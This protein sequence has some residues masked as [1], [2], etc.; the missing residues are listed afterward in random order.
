MKF[1]IN[2]YLPIAI[3]YFF[4]NPLGLPWGLLYTSLLAPFFYI[5]ILLK[6][7]EEPVFPFIAFFLPFLI[8]HIAVVGVNVQQY[9]VTMANLLAVYIFG[10]AFYTWLKTDSRK[11]KVLRSVL[12]INTAL[13]LLAVILYFTPLKNLVW[14][15]Q[16]LTNDVTDFLRLKMFTYEASYYAFLFVPVFLFFFLQYIL[17]KNTIRPFGLLVMLFLPFVLSFSA[18]VIA[19]LLASGF[20]CFFIH[21]RTL[22]NK[23]R[24]V[25]GFINITT[26]G[27]VIFIIVYIFFRGNPIFI[28]LEN[29]IT[30]NDTSASGRTGDAFVLAG[31]L[32]QQG[33]AWWG[34]GAGQLNLEGADLIRGYYL[35]Y[36]N[37]P[38]AIPNAA[39]ETLALFGWLG[40]ILRVAA[41]L[42]FFVITKSW[43]NYFRF[44][45]FVFVFIYQFT[46]SYI[47]NAAEYVIWILAFTNAFPEFDVPGRKI[48]KPAYQLS[49]Q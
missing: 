43:K 2:K 30:G 11:E 42:F 41:E 33:N 37:T 31:R 7:K 10:Q 5:W 25:N 13:C 6:R 19:C 24:V 47:T 48:V 21:F 12:F 20:A 3:V 45:L 27:V 44:M 8:A 35:Y 40:F 29:I 4:I 39:A 32:L 23:K 17:Q 1:S 9:S 18:G 28:R 38:V 16:N 14:I 26:A 34:I 22:H 36:H 15:K 49:P 46:G